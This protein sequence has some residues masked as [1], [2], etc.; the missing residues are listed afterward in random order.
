MEQSTS[1]INPP[2]ALGPEEPQGML[3][4]EHFL[5]NS[6]KIQATD[7]K[8]SWVIM[9]HMLLLTNNVFLDLS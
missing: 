6:L 9:S 8:C 4:A 3:F 1:W 2:D 7:F 5:M